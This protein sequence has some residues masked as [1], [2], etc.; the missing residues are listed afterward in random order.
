MKNHLD[1]FVRVQIA[2][3]DDTD[4]EVCLE[5]LEKMKEEIG[6]KKV[7]IF[8]EP[9]PPL[10]FQ[11]VAFDELDLLCV[12]SEIRPNIATIVFSRLEEVKPLDFFCV[13]EVPARI[14][15]YRSPKNADLD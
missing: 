10:W 1:D 3:F 7:V 14:E 6:G 8:E 13:A 9:L 5:L 12:L 4:E 15:F 2:N 11:K